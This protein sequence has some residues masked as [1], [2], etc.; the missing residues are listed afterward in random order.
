MGTSP[1]LSP[2]ASSAASSVLWCSG[3]SSSTSPDLTIPP[4]GLLTECNYDL[5][6]SSSSDFVWT[7]QNPSSTSPDLIIPPSGWVTEVTPDDQEVDEIFHLQSTE[8]SDNSFLDYMHGRALGRQHTP[9]P[10][11]YSASSRS[12][13]SCTPPPQ[14]LQQYQQREREQQQQQQRQ[15]V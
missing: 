14:L 2:I 3:E 4:S 6:S 11:Q 5:E 10:T 8:E 13:T 7:S 1:P 12:T 15:H 9:S